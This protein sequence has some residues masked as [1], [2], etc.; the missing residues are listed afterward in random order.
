VSLDPAIFT[1]MS[2]RH[3][4]HFTRPRKK[5]R[6]SQGVAS[7]RR[8]RSPAEVM[9]D[10]MRVVLPYVE[11]FT[12]NATAASTDN[13]IFRAN[14][15]YDPNYSGAGHQPLGYD[16]WTTFY[17]NWVVTQMNVKFTCTPPGLSTTAPSENNAL[18]AVVPRRNDLTTFTS[19]ST[20]LEQPYTRWMLAAGY[21]TPPMLRMSL[22]CARF[23]GVSPSVYKSSLEYSG[24]IGANPTQVLYLIVLAGSPLG[25]TVDPSPTYVTAEFE[26]VTEFYN[27]AA[28]ASS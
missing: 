21:A 1:T 16:Q 13:Y 23:L 4:K 2:T 15:L 27:A 3:G 19:V 8:L 11:Q 25:A 26:F 28:L 10:R 7:A 22:D 14:S 24:G 17:T 6:S 18:V 20:A 5:L 12:L 9:P